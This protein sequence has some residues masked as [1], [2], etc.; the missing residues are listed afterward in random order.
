MPKGNKYKTFK[1]VYLLVMVILLLSPIMIC[2]QS[3]LQYQQ[4]ETKNK[5]QSTTQDQKAPNKPILSVKT[6]GSENSKKTTD[7]SETN[8]LIEKAEERIAIFTMCLAII[9]FFQFVALIVQAKILCGTVTATKKTA[10]AAWLNAQAVINSERPW[11]VVTVEKADRYHFLFKATNVGRTP[12]KLISI[13]GEVLVVPQGE[14]LPEVLQYGPEK[15]LRINP[16]IFPPAV[17]RL[18]DECFINAI[19]DRC[20]KD[21]EQGTSRMFLVGKV[22]YS[23]VFPSM[24]GANTALHETRWGYFLPGG[25]GIPVANFCP[26]AYND[27][28]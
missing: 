15:S 2:A 3:K 18:I 12:A 25:E 8:A 26:P 5:N 14:Q 21:L 16:R 20:R 11:I 6:P 10:K 4:S 22:V 28:T 23:D 24:E 17:F 9:A 19:L 13:H 27:Y 1:C 7:Y